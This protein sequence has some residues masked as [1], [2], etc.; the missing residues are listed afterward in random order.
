[1]NGILER[2]FE[3][4]PGEFSLANLGLPQ[5][6]GT[7]QL[8][9]TDDFGNKQVLNLPFYFAQQLLKQ[10][11]VDYDYSLGYIREGLGNRSFDYGPLAFSG[12]YETGLT[13]W[14]T[15][16]IRM[17]SIRG[18]YSGGPSVI[19]KLPIGVV[20]LTDASSRYFGKS[21][22][23]DSIDYSYTRGSVSLGLSMLHYSPYYTNFSMS[24][25]QDRT[26]N[27]T[28][29]TLG[30]SAGKLGSV[31]MSYTKS[32]YRD[33]GKNDELQITESKTLGHSTSVFVSYFDT[34]TGERRTN[35]IFLG[36]NYVI[37][38]GMNAGVSY[39]VTGNQPSE[40]VSLQS[41]PP[42]G[43]GFGYDLEASKS[44]SSIDY[45][46]LFQYQGNKFDADINNEI[47]D[48]QFNNS[49][50]I[51]GAIARIDRQFFFSRQIEEGYALVEVPGVPGVKVYLSNQLMG[52][53]DG[54]GDLLIPNLL[55][56][57]ANEISIANEDIPLNYTLTGTKQLI[58]VPNRGGVVVRF[59]VKKFQVVSGEIE[60]MT[61]TGKI[62]PTYGELDVMAGGKVYTS[63]L[64]DD[65]EFY[66]ENVPSG[67]N[68][69][70]VKYNGAI[71]K[72][73]FKF[74]SNTSSQVDL[75]TIEFNVSGEGK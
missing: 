20:L 69:A 36:L 10:G 53:T 7:A 37:G 49:Y 21:G 39:E 16:G 52:K 14:L 61:P 1:M 68:P 56:Y 28:G 73:I 22:N 43:V 41:S 74:P 35:S 11:V 8:V 40:N 57:F 51:T 26:L 60:I 66:F 65:A 30:F 12:R 48:G 13:S 47:S 64:G 58:A 59:S 32:L 17:E 2:S 4:Q 29:L 9:I 33:A 31:S 38:S 46:N 23:A 19:V 45:T 72:G 25:T 34:I 54:R 50:S 62:V 67:N 44:G 71:Y 55:P 6:A 24:P 18:F 3:V 63:P 75:G 15:A 70:E 27:Q 5:G 42:A